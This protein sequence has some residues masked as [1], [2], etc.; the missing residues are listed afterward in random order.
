MDIETMAVT[1]VESTVAKTDNLV[2]RIPKRD[3]DPS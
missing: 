3:K 2:P 1:A